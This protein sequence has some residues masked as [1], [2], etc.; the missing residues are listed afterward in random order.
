M[1]TGER[2]ILRMAIVLI[3][4]VGGIALTASVLAESVYGVLASSGLMILGLSWFYLR[5]YRGRKPQR[6]TTSS[7]EGSDTYFPR[8]NI[9]RPLYEDL[10][11]TREEERRLAKTK[12]ASR[13]RD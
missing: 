10:R 3:L 12:K 6:L 9:P 7:G 1:G 5:Y 2:R 8:T 11:R 13:K 4:A